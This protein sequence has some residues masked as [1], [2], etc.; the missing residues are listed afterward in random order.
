MCHA[1]WHHPVNGSSVW[2]HLIRT[3]A[4]TG[5]LA[6]TGALALAAAPAV[7]AALVGAHAVFGSGQRVLLPGLQNI[8]HHLLH[9]FCNSNSP[10]LVATFSARVTMQSRP[11]YSQAVGT[12][13]ANLV[14][15]RRDA[16]IHILQ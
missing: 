9:C 16:S 6:V 8:C 2:C 12:V 7:T 15:K 5:A 11:S 13:I 3:L 1:W 4:L 14:E 10:S